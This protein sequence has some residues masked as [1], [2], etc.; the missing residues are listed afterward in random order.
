MKRNFPLCVRQISTVWFFNVLQTC[1]FQSNQKSNIFIQERR[2]Y[3]SYF[4][5]QHVPSSFYLKLGIVNKQES[6]R[7]LA[8]HMTDIRFKAGTAYGPLNLRKEII[9]LRIRNNFW[10]LP[11]IFPFFFISPQNPKHIQDT[12][13]IWLLRTSAAVMA[14]VHVLRS[15]VLCIT[16]Y[17]EHSCVE[18]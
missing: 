13:S 16:W 10:A 14:H 12:K 3:L 9:D 17:L 5:L 8:F 11:S 6:E 7:T 2:N 15:S 4:L 18:P 1:T